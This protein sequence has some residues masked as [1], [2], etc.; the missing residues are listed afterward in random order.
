MDRILVHHMGQWVRNRVLNID[1][2]GNGM[3]RTF[4]KFVFCKS[5][6]KKTIIRLEEIL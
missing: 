1:M 6:R 2:G 4:Y 5:N 3:G